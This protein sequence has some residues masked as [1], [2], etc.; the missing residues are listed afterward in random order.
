MSTQYDYDVLS[1]RLTGPPVLVWTSPRGVALYRREV[2]FVQKSGSRPSGYAYVAVLPGPCTDAPMTFTHEEADD[3]FLES[4]GITGRVKTGDP[5]FDDAVAIDTEASS[6]TVQSLLASPSS[7]AELRGLIVMTGRVW[8]E[9]NMITVKVGPLPAADDRA[10]EV[11][12]FDALL[13]FAASLGEEEGAQPFRQGAP[14]QVHIVPA[15]PKSAPRV[16]L[17]LA[18]TV[19]GGAGVASAF[20]WKLAPPMFPNGLATVGLC[21]GA[22]A[23][24]VLSVLALLALRGR[25]QS[26]REIALASALL[27]GLV[28]L[29]GV[30]PRLAN[31]ALPS[32]GE[33][34]RYNGLLDSYPDSNGGRSLTVTTPKGALAVPGR[35]VV[36]FVPYRAQHTPVIVESQV[37]ALGAESITRVTVVPDAP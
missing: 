2:T 19:G 27:L 34:H 18:F 13:R 15:K 26:P 24:L 9:V 16:V 21:A 31:G 30:V 10:R 11:V 7:R 1:S 36:G 28:P 33:V 25:R 29:G 23:W 32:G 14:A 17:V 37:G 6:E 12:L 4:I 22:A 35:Y 3:R 20:V 8:L 5:A